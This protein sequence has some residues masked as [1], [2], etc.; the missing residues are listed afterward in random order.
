MQLGTVN[1]YPDEAYKEGK[2]RDRNTKEMAWQDSG[3]VHVVTIEPNGK[4]G[5]VWLLW[6]FNPYD[7]IDGSRY[8]IDA[9][10]TG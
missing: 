1:F 5:S 6:D 9:S 10:G 4:A 2:S 3:Y 8:T 7:D